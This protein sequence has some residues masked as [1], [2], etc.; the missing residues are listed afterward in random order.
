MIVKFHNV[1]LESTEDAFRPTLISEECA[2]NA[3]FKN[4]NVL[5]MGCGIG[6]LASYFAKNG[7]A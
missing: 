7:A 6:H 4:K 3:A 1:E 2:L 5:D